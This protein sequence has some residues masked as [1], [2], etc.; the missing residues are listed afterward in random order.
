MPPSP[1]RGLPVS[2]HWHGC[3]PEAFL[4][5][6]PIPGPGGFICVLSCSSNAEPYYLQHEEP[7]AQKFSVETDDPLH[8]ENN[9]LFLLNY[10]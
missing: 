3:L 1:G 9:E 4:Y 7:G 8:Y 10:T 2:Q 6:L 5:L